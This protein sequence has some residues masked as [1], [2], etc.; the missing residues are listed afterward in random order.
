[1]YFMYDW[2]NNPLHRKEILY[3]LQTQKQLLSSKR[4]INVVT[5]L[6]YFS[7]LMYMTK[8]IFFS[9]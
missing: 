6:W 3:W 2:T 7:T 8:C 1:V 4:N 5:Y 9:S